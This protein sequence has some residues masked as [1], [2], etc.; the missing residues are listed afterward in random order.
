MAT[1]FLV[2]EKIWFDKFKY[3]DA[4]RKFYEQMNGGMTRRTWL[5][6][7]HAC[8]PSSWTGWSGGAPSWCPW[9]TAS[10]SCRS[11]AWWRT[12]RWAPTCWRRRSP[13]S[14]STCRVSTLRLSTRS[15]PQPQ[16]W[17]PCHH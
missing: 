5:S 9:A 4:E 16:P 15:E 17:R 10:A 13:S 8:A 12:T 3:D 7:R 1:N 14:R 2:H 6:W 11:S